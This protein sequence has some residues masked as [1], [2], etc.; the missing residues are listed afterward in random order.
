MNEAWMTIFGTNSL[1]ISAGE[2]GVRPGLGRHQLLIPIE[3]RP[4][5]EAAYG[6][7]YSFSGALSATDL[8]AGTGY[9]GRF[10]QTFPRQLAANSMATEYLTVDV[11][12]VQFDVIER[13][14][15]GGF[16]LQLDLEARADEGKDWG[17]TQILNHP[18]SREA[19]LRVLEQA[20]YQRTILV[21]LPTPDAQSAPHLTTAF[22]YF[23]NAQRRILE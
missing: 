18:V 5:D 3:V 9:L 8:G 19:W 23:A 22:E 20:G 17:S 11:D 13:R 6:H 10:N 7:R 12:P 16:S 1:A 2:L 15:N 21:E 4:T 14:R